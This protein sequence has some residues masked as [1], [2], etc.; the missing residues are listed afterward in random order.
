MDNKVRKLLFD[1]LSSIENI[2]NYIGK[3]K[4]FEH[5]IK[6]RMLKDAVERNIEIIGE[7]T[8]ILLK[9]QPGINLSNARRIVD[10]RNKII[11][12][13]DSIDAESIWAIVI[14]HLPILKTEVEKLLDES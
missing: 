10:T 1:I 4:L 14:N 5:Y 11:H 9:V 6:N 2:E 7:A 13:Y 12:S 8:N 3:P